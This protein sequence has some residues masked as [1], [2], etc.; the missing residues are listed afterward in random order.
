MRAVWCITWSC[1]HRSNNS[2]HANAVD[3]PHFYI[4]HERQ[5]HLTGKTPAER[6][7]KPG[8]A[9]SCSSPE[10]WAVCQDVTGKVK[11]CMP[12]T[13]FSSAA[14]SND[15]TDRRLSKK[16]TSVTPCALASAVRAVPTP[17]LAIRTMVQTESSEHGQ[18]YVKPFRVML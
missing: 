4:I 14:T 9:K 18:K 13:F 15:N 16:Q 6:C 2:T 7:V 5:P 8:E 11:Q 1:G 10:S 12:H 17:F 3:L